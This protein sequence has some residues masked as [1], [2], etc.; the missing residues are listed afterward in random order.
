MRHR[1]CSHSYLR[2]HELRSTTERAGGRTIPHLFL[3]QTVIC[4]LD[5]TV[6]G[7]Q[8]IVELQI[9]VDDTVLVEVLQ[10]QADLSCIEPG[11]FIRRDT[12]V[13]RR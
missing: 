1:A 3:T 13:W 9:S 8:D 12:I 11:D 7:E 6:Q 4:N 2:C 10:G 5:V